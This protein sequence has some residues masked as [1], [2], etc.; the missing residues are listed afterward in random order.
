[1]GVHF[2][3]AF[4]GNARLQGAWLGGA[5]F[6]EHSGLT[7]ARFDFA[8]LVGADLRGVLFIGTRLHGADL[9]GTRLEGANLIQAQ[10]LTQPQINKALGDV[11]TKL[12]K[13]IDP[14]AA[15]FRP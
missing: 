15:W 5:H 8:D 7:D 11:R 9:E 12:P 14:P 1:M 10:G 4:L 6:D 13:G 2:E 3:R